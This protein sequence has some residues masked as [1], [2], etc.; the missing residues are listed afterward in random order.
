VIVDEKRLNR[1]MSSPQWTN[2]QQ[3]AARD[4]LD[5]LESTLES[6]L[7]TFITPR[8]MVESAA[9]L[10]G[11]LVPGQQVVATRHPVAAVSLLDGATVDE[12]PDG[13]LPGFGQPLPDGWSLIEHRLRRTRETP[14][15]SGYGASVEISALTGLPRPG[16]SP[17]RITGYVTLSY[18]AGWGDVPALRKAIMDKAKAIMFNTHDDSVAARNMDATKAPYVQP[19][20]WTEAELAKLGTFR[21]LAAYR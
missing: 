7:M 20:D 1:Y 18:L 4:V 5:G 11:G 13:A 12:P 8:P 21:N 9:V 6:T 10:T 16:T 17:A 3:L 19:E 15:T 2:D 14:S